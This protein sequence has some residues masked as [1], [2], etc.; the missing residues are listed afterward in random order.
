MFKERFL[1]KSPRLFNEALSHLLHA[2]DAAQQ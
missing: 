2:K 1:E